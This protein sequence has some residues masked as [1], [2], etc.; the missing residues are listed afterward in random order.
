ML[1]SKSTCL[2]YAGYSSLQKILFVVDCVGSFAKCYRQ[3]M[4]QSPAI[5]PD[6]NFVCG[7]LRIVLCDLM[8]IGPSPTRWYFDS[9]ELKIASEFIGKIGWFQQFK[10][11]ATRIAGLS[12]DEV[13]AK[14][15]HDCFQIW[16]P[17]SNSS[18][19]LGL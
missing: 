1:S 16:L 5:T 2:G 17:D 10:R 14:I 4:R 7:D 9:Y 13:D 11:R 12:D 3:V 18:Q 6:I 8:F 19:G 15:G